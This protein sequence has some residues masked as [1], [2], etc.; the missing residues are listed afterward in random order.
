MK[1]RLKLPNGFGSI[2]CK[3]DGRR[4]KPYIVR[5]TIGGKQT[6]I[7]YFA[8]YE[9]AISYLVE[10]NKNPHIYSPS[11]ITFSE[12]YHCMAA[13]RFPKIA[14][15]T[16]SNYKAAFK[17]CEALYDKRFVEIRISDLQGVI[18][19]MS[20][21]GVGYASQ[22]K[23]RQLLH[24]IYSYAVKYEFIPPSADITRYIEI[25]KNKIIYPKKPFNVRQLNR[26]RALITDDNPLFK[27]AMCVVMACYAGPRPSEFINVLKSDVKLRQRF[28][29][30]R[31]SKTEAGR[32]RIVPISRKTLPYFE[33][34]MSLPGKTLI[35]DE[36]GNTL[37][38][39][40]YR[41]RFDKVMK[42]SRCKHTPHECRHTC[43]TWLDNKNANE[44]A[45]KK[46]LGH[47]CQGI[48]QGVYTHKGLRELKQAIDLL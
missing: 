7:G 13:E 43:A 17:H 36:Q 14:K 26:V 10:C 18:K 45:V 28:F 4:R 42:A 9:E 2:T 40:K 6:T 20:L 1:K 5:K 3:S 46:I 41:A 35:T 8:T 39:H 25:D 38:Y 24:H 32:N 47:A 34:W 27:W 15:S 29:V 22:K 31:D 19:N 12:M 30:I 11:Q 21:Q 16:Q 48:T 33:Y 23:C 37:S 44:V